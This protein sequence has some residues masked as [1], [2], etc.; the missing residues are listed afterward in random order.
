MDL[1]R[2]LDSFTSDDVAIAGGKGAN[3]GE[4]IGAG[5]DVPAGFVVTTSGYDAY[6]TGAFALRIQQTAAGVHLA[7]PA[8]AVNAAR[9]IAEA[10]HD[11]PLP[12]ELERAVLDAYDAL[13]GGPVAV[14]SSATAEDL[15]GASFA[16]QQDTYLGIDTPA[17]LLQAVKD[18]HASLWSDRALSYRARLAATGAPLPERL[19]LAVVV[20]RLVPAEQSGVMFTLNPG[21]GRLDEIVIDAAW[22]LGEAIVAGLVTPAEYVVRGESITG[23][24]ARQQTR[25]EAAEGGTRAVPMSGG[26]DVLDRDAVRRLADLGRRVAHHFGRPQD[27]EWAIADGRLHVLQARPVTAAAAA[28]GELPTRWPVRRTDG[29]YFR[30]SII[31]QLPD[32]LTP[33]FADMAPKAV[34]GGLVDLLGSLMTPTVGWEPHGIDFVTVNGYAY[35]E[36]TTQAFTEMLKLTP[37]FIPFMVGN[38]RS[39]LL[40]DWRDRALPRYRARVDRWRG[41]DLTSLPAR[42]LVAGAADVLAAGCAYY[43]TVQ[44][45]I[46]QAAT[47]EM[48][49]AAVYDRL[50]RRGDDPEST[51]FVIGF[52]S[53]P[54]RAEQDLYELA[55]WVRTEPSLA[56]ALADPAFDARG[57]R[58]DGVPAEVWL[59]W[60]ARLDAYLAE[61]GHTVFNLDFANPVP[62]DDPSSTLETLR[63]FVAD[64]AGDHD[65]RRR[66]E[67]TVAIRERSTEAVL[68]RLDPLRRRLFRSLLDRA[69]Q[70]APMREDALAEVG[71]GWPVLR[72]LLLELGRRLVTHGL[73]QHA[74]DVFWLTMAELSTACDTLDR[75]TGDEP[76]WSA[77]DRTSQAGLLTERL[78]TWRGQKAVTPPGYLPRDGWLRIFD[79]FMPTHEG[80]QTGPVLKGLAASSGVVEGVARVLDSPAEL[81]TMRPGEVLVASITT[82]AF[83]PLFAMASAVVT[84]VGGMLSHS[85]IVAREYGIPAVLGTG[86]ATRRISTG[87]RLRVDGNAGTVTLL[88]QAAPVP[89]PIAQRPWA[90][91]AL[92]AAVVVGL[93]IWWRRR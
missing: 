90:A 69:Q 31:E 52:D 7:S 74:D 3:L 28:R 10:F 22:G 9:G 62:A 80:E 57:T 21:T 49:F 70:A 63:F 47:A 66:Q 18:C 68:E 82:P 45:V 67:R 51:A 29:L 19:S 92:A 77:A 33:L 88:D 41:V 17:A 4:L 71:L 76:L 53:E 12:P 78:A 13:G 30:A 27:I 56:A 2:P 54:I 58:P 14:R 60:R 38:A 75:R 48:T 42:E 25:I 23:T 61:H 20:Q 1:V 35:Y 83:T 11:T 8:S 43:S 72:G 55:R 40:D 15:A 16:G 87:D 59:A 93:A 26:A 5:F 32:P 37:A 91:Y 24:P 86:V 65:P 44:T 46:P 34:V 79:S 39:T 89:A 6:V 81:A 36:Y 64:E 85:S 73:L 50:V 84:D